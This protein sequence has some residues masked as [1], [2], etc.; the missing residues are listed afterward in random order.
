MSNI[1]SRRLEI[2]S[3]QNNAS[4]VHAETSLTGKLK[5]R[6]ERCI[7]IDGSQDQECARQYWSIF[8]GCVNIKPITKYNNEHM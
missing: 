8:S 6:I 4:F 2:V 3:P 1:S 7:C 5:L